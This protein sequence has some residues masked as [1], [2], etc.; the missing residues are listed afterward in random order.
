MITPKKP[1]PHEKT[2]YPLELHPNHVNNHVA[3]PTPAIAVKPSSDRA[4][5]GLSG[6]TIALVNEVGKWWEFYCVE[7]IEAT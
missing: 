4:K 6:L 7:K 2:I 5:I 1:I 3:A